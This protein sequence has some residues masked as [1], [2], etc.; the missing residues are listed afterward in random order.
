MRWLF[1]PV[2]TLLLGPI[3]YL[4]ADLYLHAATG[5]ETA[6]WK[7][8]A[9]HLQRIYMTFTLPA[10]ALVLLVL[11]PVDLVLRRTGFG[12]VTLVVSPVLAVAAVSLLRDIVTEPHV[13][14][15]SSLWLAAAYGLVWGLTIRDPRTVMAA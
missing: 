1:R 3:L 5:A 11:L 14:A 4:L 8:A 12:L 10:L 15:W 13:Q 6:G 7:P 2:T 9:E